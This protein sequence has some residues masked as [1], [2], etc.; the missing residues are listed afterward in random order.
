MSKCTIVPIDKGPG[1][2]QV[3]A[4]FNPSQLSIEKSVP[5]QKQSEAGGKQTLEYTSGQNRTMSLELLFDT[6]EN[7]K[8]VY[9]QYVEKLEKMTEPIDDLNHPPRVAVVWAHL[10]QN[11]T[12]GHTSFIGVIERLSTKYTMF[13]EDGTPVRATCSLSLTEGH[14]A[15]VKA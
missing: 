3:E 2:D 11:G 5:W 7:G 1:L 4:Q 8:S 6:Y 15:Q 13:L 12:H 9:T 14:E 10:K